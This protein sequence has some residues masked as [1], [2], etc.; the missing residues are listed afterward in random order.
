MLDDNLLSTPVSEWLKMQ[1]YKRVHSVLPKF[2][3]TNDAAE[4]GV[5]LAYDKL[6]SAPKETMYQNIT[7][8]VEH[9]RAAICDLR[10]PIKKKGVFDC[11]T[12]RFSVPSSMMIA[13][14]CMECIFYEL[15]VNTR[16]MMGDR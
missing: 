14:H 10:I 7:Q 5:K 11:M 9:D 2:S 3:V 15:Y 1:S 13:L 4:Q 12:N 6:G 8:A 16:R